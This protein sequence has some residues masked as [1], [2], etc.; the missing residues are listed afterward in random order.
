MRLGLGTV[1]LGLPY[2]V[3]NRRGQ[4]SP[5][6]AMALLDAA[7]ASGV[8]LLDTAPAYGSAERLIG[9]A[10]AA[11][12]RFRVI[13]KT[14]AGAPGPE[15]LRAGFLHSLAELGIAR[16]DG[17]L[18]HHAG[19]ALA[20]GG[21]AL[22][23]EMRALKD[24]GRTARI[25]VSVYDA[26]ELDALL[27][28][29]APD[30]VQLPLS[31]LDQRLLHSG[32]LAKLAAQ[33]VEIHARSVF[34]QGTLIAPSA[35]LPAALAPLA[36]RASAF[37]AAL[38]DLGCSALEGALAFVAQLAEVSYAIV[39]ATSKAEFAGIAAAAERAGSRN[40]PAAKLDFRPFALDDESLVNPARWPRTAA[41]TA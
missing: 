41:G 8:E 9:E 6:E 23:D 29:F 4:P 14:L 33:G 27:A 20:P 1:Q 7:A 24:E 32:H 17:L 39:G 2:G 15:A 40:S 26:G 16:A 18:L 35:S 38:R 30:I 37:Q 13:T 25:G 5:A 11:G 36:A 19:D 10:L 28:L 21:R 12:R 22:L 31:A 34:L 3:T